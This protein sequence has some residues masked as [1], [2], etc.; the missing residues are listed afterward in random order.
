[1][2]FDNLPIKAYNYVLSEIEEKH[3]LD[4]S[5]RTAG[6]TVSICPDCGYVLTE[7]GHSD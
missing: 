7:I 4:E 1:M 3:R 5:V 6:G 2:A